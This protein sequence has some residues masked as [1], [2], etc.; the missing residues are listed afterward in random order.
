VPPRLVKMAFIQRRSI[1]VLS[2]FLEGNEGTT[3]SIAHFPG[4][5]EHLGNRKNMALLIQLRW[6]KEALAI[7][8]T[9]RGPGSIESPIEAIAA[10]ASGDVR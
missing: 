4:N 6:I 9:D 8:G 3:A 1:D 7:H 2:D 5:A 10:E